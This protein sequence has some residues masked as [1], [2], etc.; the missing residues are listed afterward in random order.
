MLLY[1]LEPTVYFLFST[2]YL[3]VL[4]VDTA[5]FL[6]TAFRFINSLSAVS[7]LLL[8]QSLTTDVGYYIILVLP[9]HLVLFLIFISFFIVSSSEVFNFICHLLEHIKYSY[10]K[11]CWI[12]LP[13][14]ACV[15]LLTII[16]CFLLVPLT[17]VYVGF[18]PYGHIW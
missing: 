5:I 8:N 11:V 13:F 2:L 18:F 16:Y 9:P 14:G 7:N 6:W 4:C 1:S 12:I 17:P 10:F 15:S 3:S